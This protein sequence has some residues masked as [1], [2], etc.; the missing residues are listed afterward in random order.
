MNE[1][2]WILI[3]FGIVLLAGIYLWGRRRCVGPAEPGMSTRAEPGMR[4][5]VSSGFEGP[6]FHDGA[7][8]DLEDRPGKGHGQVRPHRG[9]AGTALDPSMATIARPAVRREPTFSDPTQTEDLPAQSETSF[10]PSSG[11]RSGSI[12]GSDPLRPQPYPHAQT[13][14][15]AHADV[16]IDVQGR[17]GL[18]AA[19]SDPSVQD[20]SAAGLSSQDSSAQDAAE[21][22]CERGSPG[23]TDVAAPGR[24]A[25]APK[26]IERRK[27]LSLRLAATPQSLDGAKLLET[28]Q[29]E[30]L[31]HG[32]Y[33]VFHLLDAEGASIFS[34]ASMMEPGTFDLELMVEAEYPGV[35]LFAQLPGPVPG[36]HALNE[37]VACARRLQQAL[38]GSLQDD[39]GVPLTVHRIERLR[40]EIRE[41]ERPASAGGRI[42]PAG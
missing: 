37:L 21:R 19:V 28:L 8:E 42:G 40:Q 38:G 27:I 1:L 18:A 35:T 12:Q 30:G 2:R 16:Q 15:H 7:G 3:G 41:F 13:L 5:P 32:K 9:N 29:Q 23:T 34:I 31:E 17:S 39:R 22:L 24:P 20:P 33:N 36:M 14:K 4:V 11:G 6:E 10:R 25:A 26:R